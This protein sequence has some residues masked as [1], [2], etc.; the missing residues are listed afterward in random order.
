VRVRPLAIAGAFEV[1]PRPYADPRGRFVEFYRFDAL[2]EAVGHSLT[3]AQGNLSVSVRGAVRGVH[4][5]DVPPGQA[6]YVQC[7]R[8]AVLDVV[9]DVRVGSPTF[10]RWVAVRLDDADHRAVY[11]AE[12]LGHAAC[13]LTDGATLAYLCSS[14][15]A[16]AR[17]C[18][19]HPLD[20]GLGIDWPVASPL[21]ST[22]DAAAPTLAESREAGLLPDHAACVELY[23]ALERR[24]SDE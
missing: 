11:I 12:G 20:P 5:T 22:K 17:D 24:A 1:T 23:A 13:A 15:Y 10:G 14:V 6:K 19:V 9:V 16:P 4:F 2:R 8:G 3:L 18:V 7:V 21:L